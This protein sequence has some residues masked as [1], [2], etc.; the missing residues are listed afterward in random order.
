MLVVPVGKPSSKS[1]VKVV[2]SSRLV[3]LETWIEDS[4]LWQS[5]NHE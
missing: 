5:H 4:Q 2:I 1:L 3:L